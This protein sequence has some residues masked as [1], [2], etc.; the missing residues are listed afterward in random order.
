MPGVRDGIDTLRRVLGGGSDELHRDDL[1]RRAEEGIWHLGTY[2]ARGESCFPPAVQVRVTVASGS[3]DVAR[4]LIE[5]P[6]F[7][8]DLEA[9][10]LNRLADPRSDRLPACRWEVSAGPVDAVTVAED[11]RPRVAR[12]RI[13]GGDRDGV[14]V[15]IGVGQRE[16]RVGRGPWHGRDRV[17]A[18][19]VVVSESDAFVSRAAALLVQHGA[20]LEVETRDQGECLHVVRANGTRIRP[21][22]TA[23]GRVRIGPG[24][25]VVLDDGEG[26]AIS[27][28]LEDA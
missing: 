2:G 25:S 28:V 9:R 26:H 1:L 14:C 8:R 16:L 22:R 11:P 18:N 23:R 27:L 10:L 15:S 20:V 21:A 4:A 17:L 24:D 6:S 3:P 13:Q 12:L 5:D 7:A 19:D